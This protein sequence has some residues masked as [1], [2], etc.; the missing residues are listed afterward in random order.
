MAGLQNYFQWENSVANGQ[1]LFVSGYF[2][3]VS[4]SL[5]IVGV[6][7]LGIT[8]DVGPSNRTKRIL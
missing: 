3:H 6:T 8:S 2:W 4:I 1:T 5:V 7:V